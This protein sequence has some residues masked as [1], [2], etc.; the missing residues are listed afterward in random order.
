[1]IQAKSTPRVVA[2]LQARLNSKRLPRK[3]LLDLQGQPMI[4]RILER[5]S[6][7]RHIQSTVIATTTDPSDDP[8]VDY[9]ERIGVGCHRGP[10]DDLAVRL[11]DAAYAFEAE[12][13]VRVWGDCPC[14]DPEV[15]DAALERLL[16]EDLDY[17]SN[18][19]VAGRT[20]P[21]GLDFEIY[22]TTL[23]GQL[24]VTTSDPFYRE[25]PFEWVMTH[26]QEFRVGIMCLNENWSH[27][28]LTVDYPEDL[29]L[30]RELYRELYQPGTAFGW[31]TAVDW[32][33]RKPELIRGVADLIR[34]PEYRQKSDERSLNPMLLA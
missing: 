28:Y 20:Y 34:N 7:A 24:C 8:L 29:A 21:Y 18:S 10:V 25:F 30:I 26:K 19:I 14:I 13:I 31:R 23:L 2:I 6:F 15:I 4:G 1:M 32:L 3:I 17:I 27:V 5:I 16:A 11:H 33:A 12:I 9:A 22:R